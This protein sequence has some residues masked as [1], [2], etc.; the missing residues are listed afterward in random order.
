M[1]HGT[2]RVFDRGGLNMNQKAV[3][4]D[5]MVDYFTEDGLR[6]KTGNVDEKLLLLKEL[7][8][9]AL[10]AV[11]QLAKKEL[12]IEYD[13][14][15]KRLGI[16]D[17]G[18]GIHQADIEGSIYDFHVYHSSKRHYITP[19]RGK[20][21]NGLKTVICMCHL[22][23]YSLLWH[24]AEGSVMRYE[25]DDSG[26]EYGRIATEA[27]AMGTTEKHGVEIIGQDYTYF[28]LKARIKE[29]VACNPDVNVVLRYDD[30]KITY[31]ARAK[32]VDRSGDTDITFYDLERFR[33]FLHYQDGAKT[34][35]SILKDA[36]STTIAN[37]TSIRGKLKNID[38]GSTDFREDFE[39]L[40]KCQEKKK[41]TLLK[42][43]MV[44]FRFGFSN[45]FETEDINTGIP[46]I[47]EYAVERLPEKKDGV[48]CECYVNNSITYYDSWSIIFSEG[49][50]QVG[51]RKSGKADRMSYLLEPYKDYVFKFHF[52]S[53]QLTFMN[54]GKSEFDITGIMGV[55]CKELT[56]KLKEINKKESAKARKKRKKVDVMREYVDRA[57]RMASTDGKY[58]TTARQV[59]YKLREL[60]SHDGIEV[61]KNLDSE[62]K[63]FTQTVLTEYFD[64]SPEAFENIYFS[65]RG[66][67]YIGSKSY[68]LGTEA[69]RDIKR[70][71]GYPEN[72]FTV[73]GSQTNDIYLCSDFNLR[74]KYDKVLFIEKT[75]FD[76]IF[77][78]EKIGE[79]YHM[80]IVSG[81][82]FG[83]RAAKTLLYHLQEQGIKLY[84]MHDLDYHGVN[85]IHSLREPNEKF[86]EPLEITDLG[87]TLED[88]KEYKIV[89]EPVKISDDDYYKIDKSRYTP[90][91]RRFFFHGSH[92]QRVEL[93]AFTTEQILEIID[94]KLSAV[95]NLPRMRLSDAVRIDSRR[96]KEVALMNALRKMYSHVVDLLPDPEVQVYDEEMDVYQIEARAQ[97]ILDNMLTDMEV[98]AE[99]KL[100]KIEM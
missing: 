57:Y 10:D 73:D 43:H 38:T 72:E 32:A 12:L 17:N 35:R 20:Q 25:I 5:M 18:A 48:S 36:F 44:G 93:N 34:Y 11:E 30:D 58:K 83:T 80:I 7:I 65:E 15:E 53:P 56:G 62:Y 87:V 40:R 78:D 68:G 21:G 92:V 45:H 67:F 90:E 50:Y 100:K 14:K 24:T 86:S 77:K 27:H 88:I 61:L 33:A 28:W 23:G 52:I 19:S 95:N 60:A 8:D 55:L 22:M 9:N 16:F 29:Y 71:D 51:S 1:G 47:V 46:Y 79:K 13:S 69:V 41:F 3:D 76:A 26:K 74:Y 37:T 31:D 39:N 81:Q 6:K 70:L 91:Q 84:C 49:E 96:V 42:K 82:G 4:V 66:R 85:I 2:V 89:P 98:I 64:E 97:D 54:L 75:G 63:T 99:E 94:R 59:Y